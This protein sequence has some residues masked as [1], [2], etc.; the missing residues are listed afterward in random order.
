MQ[1]F[2]KPRR[3]NLFLPFFLIVQNARPG[4]GSN[5]EMQFFRKPR[6]G[7]YLILPHTSYAYAWRAAQC[8]NPWRERV[9]S[10]ELR[11]RLLSRQGNVIKSVSVTNVVLLA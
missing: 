10:A 8:I 7:I 4:E 6:R 9:L 5:G 2:G 1:F 3:G 11:K